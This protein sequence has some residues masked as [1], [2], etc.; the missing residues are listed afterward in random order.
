MG[1]INSSHSIDFLNHI[2]LHIT[3]GY[4]ISQTKS[5]SKRCQKQTTF[6]RFQCFSSFIF[7]LDPQDTFTKFQWEK[8][9]ILGE[10]IKGGLSKMHHE[11]LPV[12]SLGLYH[13][14]EEDSPAAKVE[15]H[16]SVSCLR[17][18]HVQSSLKKQ[19]SPFCLICL[20]RHASLLDTGVR[21]HSLGDL[22]R[23]LLKGD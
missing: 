6:Y 12:L 1:E 20:R 13:L 22:F 10:E 14:I 3:R 5:T 8:F 4:L 23:F 17:E 19:R 18:F 16:W 15:W 9:I 21:W 11:G 7:L 2:V